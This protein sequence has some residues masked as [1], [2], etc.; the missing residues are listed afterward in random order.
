M[1]Y[2]QMRKILFASAAL[3]VFACNAFADE[4]ISYRGAVH[5]VAATFQDVSDADGH[6]IGVIKGQGIALLPDG[7]ARA[8][9]VST[10]DYVHG[11]GPFTVYMETAFSDG[12]VIYFKGNGQAIVQGQTTDLKVPLTITGGKG[13]YAGAKGDGTLLGT[14]LAVQ[15][16]SG[17]EIANDVTLNIKK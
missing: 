16:N 9:F 2:H 12:S 5:V 1:E 8:T 6:Q 15:P 17:A 13:R 4:T 3:C 11:N 7:P 10:T 14:R